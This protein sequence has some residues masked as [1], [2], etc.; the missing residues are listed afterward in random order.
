M[1]E[2]I[3]IIEDEPALV[4]TISDLLIAEGYQVESAGD[5]E[6]GLKR[7]L[8]GKFELIILDVMLPK[9][10]GLEVCRE[11][12]QRGVDAAI[13]MLT[14]KTQV[15]DRVTGLKM[16][17]DDYVTKPFDNAELK[18]RMEALL[19]RAP[20]EERAMVEEGKFGKVTV[21]FARAEVRKDGEQVSLAGREL[22]LLQYLMEHQDRVVSRE[23]ILKKVW[24]YEGDASSR[25]VDVH[26][27]WLR[28]KLDDP[29]NPRYIQ[30]VRGKGYRFTGDDTEKHGGRSVHSET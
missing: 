12:R 22:K 28:Q 11:L 8:Q 7:A 26:V 25:T 19:R 9:K 14:A 13:L 18:A 17:A 5:G 4:L 29:E 23:E 6:E 10:T 27:A 20:R 16:G 21:D 3:L 2:S 15:G 30:T 1:H 24:E